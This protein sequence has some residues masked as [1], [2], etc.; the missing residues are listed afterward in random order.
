MTIKPN[1]SCQNIPTSV[2]K[3]YMNNIKRVHTNE[4]PRNQNNFICNVC[5]MPLKKSLN[6]I[7]LRIGLINFINKSSS[8]YLF[9][10]NTSLHTTQVSNDL[11]ARV[12]NVNW[13]GAR[14]VF[15]HRKKEVE[16]KQG[17]VLNFK[18]INNFW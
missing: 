9:T 14:N 3:I 1:T 16:G 5:Q 15:F 13:I 8:F 18:E 10:N 17:V 6:H 7:I 2:Y 4:C 11:S 12:L